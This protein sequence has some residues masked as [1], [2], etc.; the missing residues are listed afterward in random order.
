MKSLR[1][2]L[3]CRPRDDSESADPPASDDNKEAPPED[4]LNHNTNKVIFEDRQKIR[5]F[6]DKAKPAL[7]ALVPTLS[8]VGIF[9]DDTLESEYLKT[10][11]SLPVCN[12]PMYESLLY[13]TMQGGTEFTGPLYNK[14]S[15]LSVVGAFEMIA[16]YK[17]LIYH[18]HLCL[19]TVPTRIECLKSSID[20]DLITLEEA[21][22]KYIHP[23][24]HGVSLPDWEEGM[25][26]NHHLREFGIGEKK[27]D[28]IL[29]RD[30]KG[31]ISA[32][33]IMEDY[34]DREHRLVQDILA[35][36]KC[37]PFHAAKAFIRN[38]EMTI[39]WYLIPKAAT[40]F[41]ASEVLM[42][43]PGVN[44]IPEDSPIRYQNAMN[45]DERLYKNRCVALNVMIKPDDLTHRFEVALGVAAEVRRYKDGHRRFNQMM[46]TCL[47]DLFEKMEYQIPQNFIADS[48]EREKAREF[49]DGVKRGEEDGSAEDNDD[50]DDIQSLDFLKIENG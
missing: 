16:F 28:P 43:V 9:S 2:E 27:I 42:A 8:V 49:L 30:S 48:S 10:I 19:R 25:I 50:D 36:P 4:C 22:T 24:W 15:K 23:E 14:N 12:V 32:G 46:L 26:M 40:V 35:N 29:D 6:F 31:K 1:T 44:P 39:M 21:R 13:K 34:L 11:G 5:T 47:H 3:T 38:C 20:N 7:E 18:I 45:F 37:G 33:Y 17:W 41:E